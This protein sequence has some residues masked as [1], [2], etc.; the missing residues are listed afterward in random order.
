[1]PPL[2]A[3]PRWLAFEATNA[4]NVQDPL[5]LVFLPVRGAIL[6]LNEFRD[7]VVPGILAGVLDGIALG[8]W[9][10]WR[11]AETTSAGAG[12]ARARRLAIGAAAGLVA[13]GVMVA[14][15]LAVIG[16]RSRPWPLGAILFEVGSG[17]V[18]GSIAAPRALRLLSAAPAPADP[19]PRS[20]ARRPSSPAD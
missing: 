14:V 17:V 1:V 3:L 20:S 13:S 15:T 10:T 11:G 2:A 9:A 6:L 4:L 8:A 19:R 7:G 5:V 18:C 12:A 16:D